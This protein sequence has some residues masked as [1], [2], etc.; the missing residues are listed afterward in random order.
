[1]TIKMNE[2]IQS[3]IIATQA[4]KKWLYADDM[5]RKTERYR[6]KSIINDTYAYYAELVKSNHALPL[7]QNCFEAVL[8]YPIEWTTNKE[9]KDLGKFTFDY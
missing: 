8:T 1:M 3:I 7:S 9:M 4:Y 6:G 5:A 2:Q